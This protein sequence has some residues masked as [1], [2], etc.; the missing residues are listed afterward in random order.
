VLFRGSDLF[1]HATDFFPQLDYLVILVI[2]LAEIQPIYVCV[3]ESSALWTLISGLEPF[4][5]A[6][7]VEDVAARGC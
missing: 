3:Q 7:G 6:V 4:F 2:R 5:Q 1:L